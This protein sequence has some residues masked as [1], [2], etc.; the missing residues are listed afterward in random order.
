MSY[1]SVPPPRRIPIPFLR[2]EVPLGDA[3]AAG[4]EAFGVKPCD[5]CKKRK[6]WLNGRWV[7]VPWRA[8]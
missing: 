4:T 7:L 2:R 6:V 1:E 3:V 8:R 5:K